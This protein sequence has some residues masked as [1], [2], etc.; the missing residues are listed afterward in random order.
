MTDYRIPD[1]MD[2]LKRA[3][4]NAIKIYLAMRGLSDGEKPFS[5]SQMLLCHL[6]DLNHNTVVTARAELVRLGLVR[7][8]FPPGY[9][10]L[11]KTADQIL[12]TSRGGYTNTEPSS[13]M[14]PA[15][16]KRVRK[17]PARGDRKLVEGAVS[18]EARRMAVKEAC[19]VLRIPETGRYVQMAMRKL[20]GLLLDGFTVED[21]VFVAKYCR[22][23]YDE[24]DRFKKR[25]NLLYIWS[26]GEFSPILTAARTTPS[27]RKELSNIA[28]PDT[29]R[30]WSD[31]YQRR[32]KERGL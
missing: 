10:T 32:V 29:R 23:E 25:L 16:V 28:D 17:S 12:V 6:T 22:A 13:V 20:Y 21:A 2:L 4:G 15:K 31:D 7:E 18:K 9:Y 3:S 26:A 30:E 1:Y 8:A 11:C 27:H 19:R 5:A 14:L 24:G